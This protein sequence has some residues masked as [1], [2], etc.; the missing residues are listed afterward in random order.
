MERV[1]DDRRPRVAR[2][3]R[4]DAADRAGL[5][6]VRVQDRAA[7]ARRISRASRTTATSVAE[8]R[9]LAAQL[10]QTLDDRDAELLG[11]ERHRVLAARE[12]A[13]DERRVVAALAQPGREV[14]DVERGPAHVQARDHAQDRGSSSGTREERV[15]GQAQAVL[16]ARPA[17]PSRAAA[18]ALADVG[19]GVAHVARAGRRGTRFSTGLPSTS[20]IVSASALT[21]RGAP[22]ATLKMRPVASAA[23]AARTFA[24]TTF[25][26]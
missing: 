11:D 19:P 18:R 20:P 15:G 3:Q 17:A 1:H 6:G 25:S 12:L 8:R 22:A 7:A 24:S 5:R 14:G 2:E 16:E 13:R 26:T 21:L 23:S 4:R 10:R 9:D